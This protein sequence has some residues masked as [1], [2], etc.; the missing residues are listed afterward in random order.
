MITLNPSP[1]TTLSFTQGEL[2]SAKDHFAMVFGLKKFNVLVNDVDCQFLLLFEP[3]K[4]LSVQKASSLNPL[5][6][7]NEVD[8]K[9]TAINAFLNFVKPQI[10]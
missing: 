3:N 4:N 2:Q 6:G 7:Y 9:G 10:K 5:W 1:S 8:P